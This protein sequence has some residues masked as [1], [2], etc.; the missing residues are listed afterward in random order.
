MG[1]RRKDEGNK[2]VKEPDYEYDEDMNK[3]NKE[4]AGEITAAHVATLTYLL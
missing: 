3:K 1:R 2:E 4:R